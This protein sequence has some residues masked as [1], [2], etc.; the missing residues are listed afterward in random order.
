MPGVD[1]QAAT[2]DS[3]DVPAVQTPAASLDV[4]GSAIHAAGSVAGPGDLALCLHTFASGCKQLQPVTHA[5]GSTDWLQLLATLEA[6]GSTLTD[7]TADVLHFTMSWTKAAY[8]PRLVPNS[9]NCPA[10]MSRS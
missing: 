7:H 4:T 10:S 9:T 6:A 5:Q 8:A 3:S 1:M 2:D